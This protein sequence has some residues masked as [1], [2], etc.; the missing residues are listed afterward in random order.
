MKGRG[1][2]VVY[3]P[4]EAASGAIAKGRDERRQRHR[5]L[6]RPMA[7]PMHR[8]PPPPRASCRPLELLPALPC[9]R[10]SQRCKM[11]E[12]MRRDVIVVF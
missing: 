1:A 4:R 6:S 5:Q 10:A 9:L 7:R 3:R 11:L 2:A 12:R 8:A